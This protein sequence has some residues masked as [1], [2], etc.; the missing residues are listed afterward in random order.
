MERAK[1]VRLHRKATTTREY[2]AITV[3]IGD[4]KLSCD[5]VDDRQIRIAALL[6]DSHQCPFQVAPE[7]TERAETALKAKVSEF[8]EHLKNVGQSS[9]LLVYECG[10]ILAEVAKWDRAAM[11]EKHERARQLAEDWHEGVPQANQFD[12]SCRAA[13]L[14][15]HFSECEKKDS[16]FQTLNLAEPPCNMHPDAPHGFDRNASHTAGRYV[17]DCEGWAEASPTRG[18]TK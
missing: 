12:W 3:C 7:L 10:D 2:D 14:L 18:D 6:A 17:C 15:L 11:N 9:P 1:I 8:S 5:V 4:L 13:G 16:L